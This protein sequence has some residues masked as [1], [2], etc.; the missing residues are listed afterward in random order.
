MLQ[1]LHSQKL[2]HAALYR[3]VL[4]VNEISSYLLKLQKLPLHT[5]KFFATHNLKIT[6]PLY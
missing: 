1:Y 4:N 2:M 3:V 6:A 5:W